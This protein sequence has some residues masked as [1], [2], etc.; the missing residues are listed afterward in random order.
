MNTK[1]YEIKDNF[2][3]GPDFEVLE[4]IIM[5][6]GHTTR[7]Q[8]LDGVTALHSLPWFFRSGMSAGE[9]ERSKKLNNKFTKYETLELD[10]DKLFQHI[11][12]L[13]AYQSNYIQAIIPLLAAIDPLAFCRIV[14]N[15]TLP[16]KENKRSL[17]HVDGDKE[18]NPSSESMTTSIFYMNTTNGPTIL[19]DGTEIECRANRLVSYS[20][21]TQHAAVLCTDAEYRV[22]INLN[23]FK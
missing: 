3:N 19:E 15:L 18:E 7:T 22:V 2:I 16:Q 5:P 6:H 17:F 11:F 10:E 14:A 23:Y 12:M 8:H 13:K 9:T 4:D 1:I 21:E 20:N